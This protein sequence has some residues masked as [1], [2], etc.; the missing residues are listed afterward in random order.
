MTLYAEHDSPVV[1]ELVATPEEL[2]TREFEYERDAAVVYAIT[3]E[4]YKLR[5]SDGRHGWIRAREAG[6]FHSLESRLVDGL[7]YLTLSWDK[8][9]YAAPGGSAR[10]L[11]GSISSE[12]VPVDVIEAREHDGALWVRVDAL[13][14]ICEADPGTIVD[15]GWV[16]VHSAKG[17]PNVWFY[18]RGC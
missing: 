1:I 13:S 12:N 15:R 8:V 10:P 3:R 17:D 18:S 11:S 5:L 16:A 2:E 7:T 6:T 9:I 4:A 14:S